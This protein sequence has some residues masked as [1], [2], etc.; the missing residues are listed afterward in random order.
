[1]YLYIYVAD[2][3]PNRLNTFLIIMA[4]IMYADANRGTNSIDDKTFALMQAQLRVVSQMFDMIGGVDA[5]ARSTSQPEEAREGELTS[6][7]YE[8]PILSQPSSLPSS[9][10]PQ[11]HPV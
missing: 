9:A 10:S 6:L 4:E 5:P 2:N 1:M 8:H 3:A 11:S 7:I